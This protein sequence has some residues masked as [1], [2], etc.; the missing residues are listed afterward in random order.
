MK[1]LAGA[2]NRI[3]TGLNGLKKQAIFHNARTPP[4]VATESCCAGVKY[5]SVHSVINC[6]LTTELVVAKADDANVQRLPDILRES[7]GT[8]MP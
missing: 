6:R 1:P 3:K 7:T 4:H 5:M 8:G 2:H